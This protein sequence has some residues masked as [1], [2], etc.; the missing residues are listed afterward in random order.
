MLKKS[1]F[2]V[3]LSMLS[4]S[5]VARSPL[6]SGQVSGP[7]SANCHVTDGTF[8][9][10]ASGK[11]EWSDVTPV[12]F[13]ASDSYLYVNQDASHSF[14]YLMYDLPI[15]TTA[16]AETDSVHVNFYTVEQD[17][18][19]PVLI[20]YDVFIQGNGQMQILQQ[21]KPTPPGRIVSAIGFGSSPNSSTPHVMAELQVP[22]TTGPPSTYSPDPLYWS[23]SVPP[24]PPPPPCPTQPGKSFNDCVKKYASAAGTVL[25]LG[26]LAAGTV[27]AL[28]TAETIGA[29]IPAETPLIIGGAISTGLGY[30]IDKYI[31]GDPPNVIFTIPPDS[32][33]TVIA[34]PA[35]YSVTIP[36]TGTTPDEAAALNAWFAAEEQAIALAQVGITSVARAEG[37]SAAGSPIWVTAQTQ[38]A[39]KYGGQLGTVLSGLPALQAAVVSAFQTS[40][41]QGVFSTSN[42]VN[43]QNAITSS[44]SSEVKEE[45]QQA[46]AILAQLGFTSADQNWVIQFLT[47]SDPQAAAALGVGAFPAV[48]NDPA[49][50]TALLQLGGT[51]VLNAPSPSALSTA[52]QATLTGDYIADGIGLR[53]QTSGNI[54]LTGIPSGASVVKAL[55][56]WAYLDNGE[57]TSLH[58]LTMNGN[59]ISG[60]LIGSGP[61]TCWGR[62]NS[63]TYRSD[64]TSLVAGNATYALT[65]VAS[66]GNI[67]A[68]GAS[69]VVVYQLDS[70]PAKTI[71][72]DDG[73]L[74]MPNGSSS[75]TASFG[76]FTAASPVSATTTFIVG[77]GQGFGSD[78]SFTGNA[79]T[80]PFTNL[81][82]ANDGP[83]W[84]TDTFNVSSVIGSGSDSGSANITITGDCL[85]W[86]A[87]AFSVTSTPVTTPVTVTSGVVEA[88]AN[89]DTIVNL[90]G[91]APSDAPTI[92]DQIAMIVQF[93]II[94]NPSLSGPTLTT[95]LV[96]GLVSDGVISSSE[97]ETIEAAVN[98]LVVAPSAVAT[99]TAVTLTPNSNLVAGQPLTVV[100]TVTPASGSAIPTGTVT[101]S[102]PTSPGSVTVTLDSTGKATVKT[103]VPSAG[104]YTLMATYNGAPGFVSSV[105][106]QVTRTVTSGK[107]VA[108]TTSI[109]FTP[110]SN[111]I[112]GQPLTVVAT[113]TPSSGSAIPTG[114]VTF[115]SP[116]S[117]GS[118]TVTLDPTG[119][120]TLK[121]IIPSPGSYTLI[122]TYNGSPGFATSF[123]PE[124]SKT[125]SAAK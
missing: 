10:C 11:Q 97:A 109:V 112:A 102:S 107:V 5:F 101:F 64:V 35:A 57:D 121:T 50:S 113:V 27:G 42:V 32:N 117:P 36:T 92:T 80:I 91:L 62:S 79:G 38:A 75:G 71:I 120:A 110:S 65:D 54:M 89:G 122:A 40:G 76:S 6:A 7:P 111:L 58:Q 74:S 106:P 104:S 94:Q 9:A 26:G 83:L 37:A 55:L 18:G 22:L 66:G 31:A 125:V 12:A 123:S 30:L 49:S 51:L 90:R 118:A 45:F 87:Q 96:N 1:A 60:S 20:T 3:I 68:E 39:Q 17:A 84:D 108:T 4:I 70:A 124:V 28:C 29:C 48:L 78:T 47:T 72:I 115:S 77:D 41:S 15:R 21:G 98:K 73:N 2:L 119:K 25:T 19:L 114:T 93:R 14:L 53:G 95:Q 33:Y 88:G 81:F 63:F 67:L 34:T 59:A 105:S 86:S 56:Y 82:Q 85:L 23:A 61:D 116:T 13:P 100:A 69:L 99:S 8:T 103:I 44:T 46:L 24:T 52:Y 43:F 16:L